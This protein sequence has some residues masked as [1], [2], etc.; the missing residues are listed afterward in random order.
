[1]TRP[2]STAD[3]MIQLADW[4]DEADVIIDGAFHDAGIERTNKGDDVQRDLRKWAAWMMEHPDIDNELWRL[5]N[6]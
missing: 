6:G 5:V 4:L 3:E 2:V 1:M